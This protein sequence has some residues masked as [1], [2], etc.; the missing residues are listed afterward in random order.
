MGKGV[1]AGQRDSLACGSSPL[2]QPC[3]GQ[4]Q[5]RWE[6]L[7]VLLYSQESILDSPNSPGCSGQ[8]LLCLSI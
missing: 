7:G 2:L 1:G 5:P 8:L 4:H 3:W 6:A